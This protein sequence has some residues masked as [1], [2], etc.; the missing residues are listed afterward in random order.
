MVCAFEGFDTTAAIETD[1]SSLLFGSVYENVE[2]LP[3]Y[4]QK[5]AGDTDRMM[6]Q[7]PR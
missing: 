6:Q 5:A 2:G 1:F 7:T 4:T 3:L